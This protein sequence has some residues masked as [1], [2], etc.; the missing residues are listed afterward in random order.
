MNMLLNLDEAIFFAINS[1]P[2]NVV[3]N[4][5][6]LSLS[7]YP[8]I[9]WILIGLIVMFIEGKKDRWFMVRLVLALILAGGLVSGMIK[10]LVK[11]PRPDITHGDKVIVVE[12][13]PAAIPQHNDFAFPS[14]HAALAFAG[15]Y[16]VM[17]EEVESKHNKNQSKGQMRLMGKTFFIFAFLTAFSRMY[18][19][20]HYPLDVLVGGIMGWW[21]GKAAWKLVDF[22]KPK[23][24]I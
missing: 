9:V 19:G 22:I 16:I 13:K 6:F 7:F 14:G 3:L 2:H 17:R 24:A 11:R 5:L 18:L 10:P 21:M 20:K 4:S 1:L 23:P 8:L 12:E 15:A